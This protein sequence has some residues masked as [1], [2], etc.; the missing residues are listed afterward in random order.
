M[1]SKTL[2]KIE[3]RKTNPNGANQYLLDPRQKLCWENYTHPD[4]PTF[5]NATQSAI[6]AGYTEE[7]ANVITLTEWFSVRLWKLNATMVGEKKIQQLIDLPINNK[8][9]VDVGI[10]RVQADLAKY[11]TSTL[12][13]NDG[14]STRQELSGPNGGAIEIASEEKAKIIKALNELS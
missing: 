3:D 13:K 6:S 2:K 9:G 5:G 10:I 11:I 1:A 8:D 4:S 7:T 14:Y 12:G